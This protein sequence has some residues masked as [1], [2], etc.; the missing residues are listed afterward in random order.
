MNVKNVKKVSVFNTTWFATTRA[1][2]SDTLNNEAFDNKLG[3]MKIQMMSAPSWDISGIVS[4][5]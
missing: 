5:R 2:L 1:S 4:M 3:A